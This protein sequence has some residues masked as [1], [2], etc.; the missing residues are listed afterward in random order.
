MF[1][2]TA[3][4][5][6]LRGRV[7]GR[8]RLDV[9]ATPPRLVLIPFL[10]LA[11]S[12]AG[13]RPALARFDSV[14]DAPATVTRHVVTIEVD[15][16]GLFVE[17][18][19]KELRI[20]NEA[21]RQ[22]VGT[23]G[24]V[25]NARV[26]KVEVLSAETVAG[27]RTLPVP[28]EAI[29]DKPVATN[30]PGFDEFAKVTIPYTGVQV[31]ASVRLRTRTTQREAAFPGHFSC[32]FFPG[33]EVAYEN[34]DLTIRSKMPLQVAVNDPDNVLDLARA[35][36]GDTHTVRVRLTKPVFRRLVDE[37]QSSFLPA[38]RRPYVQSSTDK[39]LDAPAA[40]VAAT[41]EAVISEPLPAPF[42]ELAKAF[43]NGSGDF[44]DRLD[45]LTSSFSQGVRYFG[46]W[47]PHNGGYVPRTL[48]A[49]ASSQY[50]DCK[51]MAAAVA[52]ILRKAG[53]RAD[54]AWIHRGTIPPVPLPL[55]T[56]DAYNH[57]IVRVVQDGATYWLDPTNP[58]SFARGI[59]ADL[60]GRD[61]LVLE[62]GT[63]RKAQVPLPP[64][65]AGVIRGI[66]T[67]VFSSGGNAQIT[68][69]LELLGQQA[70]WLTG[71]GRYAPPETVKFS[72][73]RG[74]SEGRRVISGSI[75][76][77]DMVSPVVRDISIDFTAEIEGVA[78]RTTAGLAYRIE[79]RAMRTF[80]VIDPE[81]DQGDLFLG[82]PNV[83][84]SIDRIAGNRLVGKNPGPC[85][86][87]SPWVDASWE[88]KEEG[89]DLLV[90][91]RV[92]LKRQVL[93]HADVAGPD[94][95]ELQK[96]V[97]RCFGDYALVFERKP[98][99]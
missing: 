1:P 4:P 43:G 19:E 42:D 99:P 91:S 8:R 96:G 48:G 73:L 62:N 36:D 92:T 28:R 68:G 24:F 3:A 16:D 21:G 79:H 54:V 18:E 41:Y 23:M 11:L 66:G 17:E 89:D 64:P 14:K 38:D 34:F 74:I 71:V 5:L 49:I 46:D 30:L 13:P 39:T 51:D 6:S 61:A 27:E 32:A 72:I 87:A 67:Y 45:A 2:L 29:E 25:Y 9:R 97:R 12:A 88:A 7:P 65:D 86:V 77:F 83:T 20:R 57:A 93:T 56:P 80:S 75:G 15:R 81:K 63:M 84:D 52:A 31:G 37:Q 50:G 90:S 10:A 95:A 53:V 33:S 70:F 40:R 94:F 78:I 69:R 60:M 47:R 59:P 58:V 82:P 35:S 26:S 44:A 55:G 22:A 76:D 85:R 98:K